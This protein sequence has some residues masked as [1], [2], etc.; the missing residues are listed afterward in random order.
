MFAK[1][2]RSMKSDRQNSSG[3]N[4]FADQFLGQSRQYAPSPD[5]FSAFQNSVS[6]HQYQN[7][8]QE[9]QRQEIHHN[10]SP[11][12]VQEPHSKYPN[13]PA[14]G[15]HNPQYDYSPNPPHQYL[16]EG[17]GYQSQWRYLDLKNRKQ[18]GDLYKKILS[19]SRKNKAK[20]FCFTSSLAK[21]GVTTVLV[22]LVNY[23]KSQGANKRTIVIDAS[24]T[25]PN[26]SDVFGM[27][28]NT[29]GLRDILSRRINLES[30][31]IPIGPNIWTLGFGNI[32]PNDQKNFEP[33]DFANVIKGCRQFADFILIDCPPILNSSDALSVA[34]AADVSFLIVQ[35]IKVR[36]QVAEKALSVL[37]NNE[38]GLNGVI[39]NKV[40]QVIPSWLYKYI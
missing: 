37:Q 26:L 17:N 1:K 38:C 15:H 19:E 7:A 24:A 23:I 25:P 3:K 34:P 8:H 6:P 12:I 4:S 14:G 29:P 5:R 11:G 9:S 2:L 13:M 18:T 22:N 30:A 21:E 39:L 36:R 32:H 40:Q 16:A 27:P 35:A 10:A 33:E 20:T 31:L 28:S